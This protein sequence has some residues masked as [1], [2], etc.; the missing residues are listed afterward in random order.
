M[1]VI[2]HAICVAYL[3]HKTAAAV[4]VVPRPGGQRSRGTGT[5]APRE[6]LPGGQA[7]VLITACARLTYDMSTPVITVHHA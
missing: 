2:N 6:G 4:V 5:L 7:L 3:R 1:S